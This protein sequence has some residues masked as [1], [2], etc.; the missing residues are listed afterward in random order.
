LELGIIKDLKLEEHWSP[1]RSSSQVEKTDPDETF[2]EQPPPASGTNES[3]LELLEL[4]TRD[5]EWQAL[6]EGGSI[7]TPP[8][9]ENILKI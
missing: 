2:F 8:S 5:T 4:V 6:F 1:D 7:P 9:K 3:F